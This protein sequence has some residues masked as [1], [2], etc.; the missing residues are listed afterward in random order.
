M[1][2][3]H[4][5]NFSNQDLRNRSFKG[6]DLT[7]AN[8]SGS[9]IRG[10]DFREA[11]LQ[12]ANFQYVTAGRSRRQVGGLI[13]RAGSAAIVT[14]LVGA[15]TG[16]SSGFEAGVMAIVGTGIVATV[17]TRAETGVLAG[18]TVGAVAVIGCGGFVTFV[19]G[20]IGSGLVPMTGAMIGV[21]FAVALF[22]Q[23]VNEA[24]GAGNTSF[25]DADLTNANFEGAIVQDTEF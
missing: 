5:E 11:Q 2:P 15:L 4:S 18:A 10:C 17:A 12:G 25:R 23:A 14:T 1:T 8:F 24:E 6:Q 3:I 22:L 13:A 7:G 20:N 21:G 19:Q 9:D 16:L